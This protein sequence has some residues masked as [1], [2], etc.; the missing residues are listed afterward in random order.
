MPLFLT[1]RGTITH[2]QWQFAEEHS[3]R[4]NREER[5]ACPRS[6]LELANQS[7]PIALEKIKNRAMQAGL[8]FVEA[9]NVRISCQ[10]HNGLREQQRSRLDQVTSLRE[11]ALSPSAERPKPK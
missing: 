9:V 7:T 1:R 11:I 3:Y 6:V 4:F 8:E 5:N 2:G 10:R